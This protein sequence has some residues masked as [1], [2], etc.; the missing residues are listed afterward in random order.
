[1][2]TVA[3]RLLPGDDLK[4]SLIKLVQ[5]HSIEAGCILSGVGSL[6]QY[7]LR[8][9]NQ[10]NATIN[11]TSTFE[12]VSLTGTLSPDG[13][14]IHMSVS[15]EEGKTT[16]GHLMDGNLVYTTAELVIAKLHGYRFSREIDS[17]TGFLELVIDKVNL[18]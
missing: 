7:S 12:I 14:H 18:N 5:E 1:M 4:L 16:G 6:T 9:A 3:V 17:Q 11:K 15:D 13:V 2:E 10:P 8:F